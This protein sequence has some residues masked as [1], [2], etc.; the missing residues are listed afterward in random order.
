MT[1]D[2][3]YAFSTFAAIGGTDYEGEN[4]RS[5]RLF[6][7]ADAAIDYARVLLD[8]GSDYAYVTGV[9][10]DGSLELKDVMRIADDG[11]D[12]VDLDF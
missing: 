9:H 6:G 2:N 3:A 1:K 4:F 8:Q 5:M 10:A 12:S 11:P 7:S